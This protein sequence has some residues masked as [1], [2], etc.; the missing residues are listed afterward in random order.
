VVWGSRTGKK[1]LAGKDPAHVM[2]TPDIIFIVLDTQRADRLGCY[3]HDRPTSPNLDRFAE[4]SVLFEQAV[5]PAQ[6]TIPSHASLFTGQYPTTHGVTQSSQGLSPDRP[7]VAEVLG[8]AGYETIGFCNNPLVGILNNGFKRGFETFYN[9]GGAIPSLPRHSSPLPAPL[10]YLGE[11]YTQ[12]LRKISYPIQNFFGQ[13]DLAFRVS[14]N[15]WLTPIWSKLA[16]FKGQNPRSV[17]DVVW[18]LDQRE[19]QAPE[20]PLFLFLNLMETHLPFW[21]P[22]EY[23]D[24]MAPYI[25]QSK[26]ARTIMRDWNREAYRWAAPLKEPLDE[27]ESRVL[28]D[29]Y[30][31]EVAFQDDYLGRLFAALEQRSRAKD[32]I[33][34]IVADHGDG[35]GDHGY[36][37]HAFV[38]YE[39]L[40][41][42]PLIVNWPGR[43]ETGQRISTPVS[44]RRI[45][46]TLVEAA[47]PAAVDELEAMPGLD[48]AAA[49]RLSLRH[50]IAGRDPEQ[51]T[52]YSEVYPPMNFAKAIERRQPE[53][54]DEFRCL[55]TRRAVVRQRPSVGGK[56]HS[57]MKLIQIEGVAEEL[58]DLR[59]DP[60]ELDNAVGEKPELVAALDQS[61]NQ[62]VSRVTRERDAS[63]SGAAAGLEADELL[64]KRLRGLGYLE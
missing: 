51:Q 59:R 23:I 30:D 61:L 2:T 35:L 40:V 49:R 21:P 6:W 26:E 10:N 32:T 48:L 13:S 34:V 56:P 24:R 55:E 14:L 27:L 4:R 60:L 17:K 41:H 47:A 16:N 38:A 46:H 5:S 15:A 18:Y 58:Y 29:L 8:Q 31:A 3:G 42:V 53:L 43:Y 12:F 54:L 63:P 50:T 11:G 57:A 20:Q 7:H 52:A 28:N 1:R 25:R 19:Q 9:Y 33:T 37:G 36:F 44:T 64:Q 39:E 62:M 22:G 45:F